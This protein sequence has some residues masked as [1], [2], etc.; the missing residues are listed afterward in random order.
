MR[1]AHHGLLRRGMVGRPDFD[2]KQLR[3]DAADGFLSLWSLLPWHC[4][5]IPGFSLDCAVA[6]LDAANRTLICLMFA[7][8]SKLVASMVTLLLLPL[9]IRA[10]RLLDCWAS[11]A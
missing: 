7:A 8:R 4:D 11:D 10:S 3:G 5:R 9:S 1:R 2:N 6:H